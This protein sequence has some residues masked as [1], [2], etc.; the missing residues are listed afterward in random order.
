MVKGSLL[1][2][3]GKAD[4]ELPCVSQGSPSRLLL[5]C[6]VGGST[7]DTRLAVRS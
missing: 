5:P 6:N 4:L 7:S 3:P 2:R 1:D